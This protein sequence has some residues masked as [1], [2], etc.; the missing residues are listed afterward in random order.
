[1]SI[2]PYD[3]RLGEIVQWFLDRNVLLGFDNV[4]GD[5]WHAIM[6]PDNTRIGSAAYGTGA[7][8][9]EA[10]EAAQQRSRDRLARPVPSTGPLPKQA[11]IETRLGAGRH[12]VLEGRARRLLR[13]LRIWNRLRTWSPGSEDSASLA[14][15]SCKGVRFTSSKR[16]ARGF[17]EKPST[18]DELRIVALSCVAMFAKGTRRSSILGRPAALVSTRW[19][20]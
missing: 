13:A 14:C 10:A 16:D 12:H 19:S 20:T 6:L 1:M 17:A 4:G 5:E 8:K 2:E 3:E 9:L 7:T 18:L 11:R 15:V